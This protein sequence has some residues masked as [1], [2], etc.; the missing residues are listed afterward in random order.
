MKQD[1][2]KKEEGLS[3]FVIG[4][5]FLRSFG[6]RDIEGSFMDDVLYS[7]KSPFNDDFFLR[8]DNIKN[9]VIARNDEGDS[10]R[11]SVDDVIINLNIEDNQIDSERIEKILNYLEVLFNRFNINGI[12]RV[13]FV[14]CTRYKNKDIKNALSKQIGTALN[15]DDTDFQ[16]V[17]VNLS[18]KRADLSSLASKGKEDYKNVNYT[19]ASEE[20]DFFMFNIDSQKYFNPPK[21]DIRDCDMKNLFRDAQDFYDKK[22]NIFVENRTKVK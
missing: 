16:G 19:Y 10:F 21:E 18:K 9:G 5:R 1:K 4:I 15:L 13:G 8:L 2:N 14:F 17:T 11:F 22:K 3:G 7:K 12:V 6:A 20:E